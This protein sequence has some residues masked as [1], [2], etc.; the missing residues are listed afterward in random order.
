MQ[1]RRNR[2]LSWLHPNADSFATIALGLPE[3]IQE[4]LL[5]A[6]KATAVCVQECGLSTNAVAQTEGIFRGVAESG[7]FEALLQQI[8]FNEESA[9]YVGVIPLASESVFDSELVQLVSNQDSLTTIAEVDGWSIYS[10]DGWLDLDGWP[11]YYGGGLLDL[12]LE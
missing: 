6:G 5:N 4:K 8:S 2:S 12:G 11:I 1:R 9:C 10:A 7:V 3:R